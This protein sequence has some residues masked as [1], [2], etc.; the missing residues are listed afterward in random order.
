MIYGEHVEAL[1]PGL[2]K[3]SRSLRP[4]PD[5]LYRAEVRLTPDEVVPLQRALLRVEAELLCE[6]ADQLA[7]TEVGRTYELRRADAVLRLVEAVAA[8]RGRATAPAAHG[9][10]SSGEGRSG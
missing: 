5:G 6:D 3:L 9:T 8:L 2:Q 1:L 4:S 7:T 10:A